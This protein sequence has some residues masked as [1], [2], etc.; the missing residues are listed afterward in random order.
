MNTAMK[1]LYAIIAIF[2]LQ[3]AL[4]SGFVNDDPN[5]FT[6][7]H[8]ALTPANVLKEPWT[9]V[10]SIFIHGSFF[11]LLF[12][13]IALFSFGPYLE[14]L[15][16]KKKFLTL[17]FAGG[18]IA[19]LLFILM[20]YVPIPGA[21]PTIPGL[22]A[23]GAIMA[24]IGALTIIQPNLIVLIFF[25]PVPLWFA[26]LFFFLYDL[27]AGLTASAAGVGHFAHIGGLLFGFGFA[28]YYLHKLKKQIKYNEWGEEVSY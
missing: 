6:Y 13:G 14:R 1:L 28:Y 7:R 15:L 22:G 8:L 19:S 24:L 16:G 4:D 17:F 3:L 5:A 2:L 21:D 12:N 25:F 9:L 26:G 23:S 11:H 10:T 20:A 27:Y 18:I